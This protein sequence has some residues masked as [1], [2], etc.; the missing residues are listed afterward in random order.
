LTGADHTG[1]KCRRDAGEA[2]SWVAGTPSEQVWAAMTLSQ[3][4]SRLIVVDGVEYRWMV[5]RRPTYI[6]A[7][8]WSS[9]SFVVEKPTRPGGVLVVSTPWMHPGNWLGLPSGAVRPSLVASAITTAL[10]KGWLSG[11][12]NTS[13]RMLASD[14]L[15]FPAPTDVAQSQARHD[16]LGW[17]SGVAHGPDQPT[18]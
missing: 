10:A 12:T 18:L 1:Q 6:Q 15:D 4:R 5:R 14:V 17:R 7:L 9:L 16:Q 3:K 11:L 8:G 13:M 2:T